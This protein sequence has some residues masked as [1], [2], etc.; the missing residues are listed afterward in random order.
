MLNDDHELH[1]RKK[2]LN[3]RLNRN[4]KKKKIRV[5]TYS[6]KLE[7]LAVNIMYRLER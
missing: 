6:K 3:L 1:V 4:K 2:N 7:K 5:N